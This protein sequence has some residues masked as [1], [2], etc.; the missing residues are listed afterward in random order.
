MDFTPLPF[1]LSGAFFGG[2]IQGLAGFG[3]TLIALPVLAMGMDM[4]LAVPVC[5]T[6]SVCLNTALTSR[7][8]THVRKDALILLLCGAIPGTPLGV[9]ALRAVPGHWLKAALAL[10]IL[11]FVF[12]S[13]R[14]GRAAPSGRPGRFWGLAAG[15]TA[16]CLGGAIGVNGPPIAAWL[17]RQGFDRDALRGTLTAFF[18]LAACAVVTSQAV[19]GLITAKVMWRAA[20]AVPTLLAGMAV[21]MAFCGRIGESGFHRLVL[22]LLA[23]T[24]VVLLAQWAGALAA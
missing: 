19:A 7:L 3:S 9:S 13:W 12:S 8:R 16:G 11:A 17:C 2:F 21:G 24:A 22:G 5:T 20:V 4:Q 23:L 14:A 1:L 10:G 15:F 18:L 6:L